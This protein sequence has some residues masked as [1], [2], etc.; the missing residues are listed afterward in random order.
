MLLQYGAG[1]TRIVPWK[2]PAT[3]A[4]G[5]M[6]LS[7]TGLCDPTCEFL[8][9]LGTLLSAVGGPIFAAPSFWKSNQEWLS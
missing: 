5:E 9:T 1:C 8:G 2:V 7:G 6:A 4:I 3:G